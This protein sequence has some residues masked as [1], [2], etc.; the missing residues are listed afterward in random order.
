MPHNSQF[1]FRDFSNRTLVERDV[2]LLNDST[3]VGSCFSQNEPDTVV[4]PAD[5]SGLVLEKCNLENAMIPAGVTVGN[6]CLQQR[7][8]TQADGDFR[9]TAEAMAAF[10]TRTIPGLSYGVNR[11]PGAFHE[12][13]R[14]ADPW[15][16]TWR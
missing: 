11:Q 4:F 16:A 15:P 3:I 1:S 6:G 7:F 10:A 5:V 13:P 12:P 8:S 14:P 9:L 2:E